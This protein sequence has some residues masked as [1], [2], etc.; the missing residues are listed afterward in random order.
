MAVRKG[1]KNWHIIQGRAERFAVHYRGPQFH[2]LITDAPYEM[3]MMGKEWDSSGLAFDSVFWRTISRHILPGGFVVSMAS[4]RGWHR[5]AKAFEDAGLF[6]SPLMLGWGYGQGWSKATRICTQIDESMGAKRKVVGH[7]TDGTGTWHGKL[8]NHGP[9]DTG[10]GMTDGSGQ[11]YDVTAPAT[12][13]AFAWQGHRYGRQALK[14]AIEP[15]IVAQKLCDGE[16]PAWSLAIMERLQASDPICYVAKPSQREKSAGLEHHNRHLS[17]KPVALALWLA[18]L[19][20]PS[21]ESKTR[22]LNPFSGSGTEVIGAMLAGWGEVVGIELE[23]PSVTDAR[24]RLIWWQKVSSQLR[25]NDMG[26]ILNFAN[27]ERKLEAPEK[28]EK[29]PLLALGAS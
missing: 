18:N 10:I 29:L 27:P 5:L 20:F 6:V 24:Q 25:T 13:L 3:S 28:V 7:R 1:L 16:L 2:V 4:S 12:P 11:Q 21:G 17:V 22:L 15:I 9:G 19:F 8:A 26:K 23:R 14:P